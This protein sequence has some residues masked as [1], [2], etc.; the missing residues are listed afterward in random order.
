MS[1]PEDDGKVVPIAGRTKSRKPQ[2]RD[3][4]DPRPV[5]TIK[6]GAI[7][8]AVDA[9]EKALMERGGLYQ[10]ANQIVFLGDAP[11]I[12]HDNR[13]VTA[14][15]IFE[16]G[17]NALAEDIGEAACLMKWD[18]RAQVDVVVDTPTRLVKT[19]QDR[20]GR[21]RFP[22]LTAVVNAP[23]LRAD[24]SLLSAPGYDTATGLFFDPRGVTFP[25]IPA[26]PTR[27]DAER[28]LD[29]LHDLIAGF[30][31]EGEADRAV[32]LS[33]ILTACAR[34]GLRT[35]PMHAFSAPVAGSGKSKLVDI[36]SAIATGREA[37]VVAQTAD[38]AE[39]E[40]RLGALY[41]QGAGIV[42]IDNCVAPVNGAFLCVAL[43]QETVTIRPLGTSTQVEVPTTTFLT[44]T[45]NNLVIA[46]DMTRRAVLAR[47]DPRMERPELREF[48]F[49]PVETAKVHRVRYVTAALTVMLA[50]KAAG[51]PYQTT[52]L[53]SFD[54]WSRRV[55]D[56]LV[57]L[58]C[59]DPVT[60]M[61]Q[62]RE[63][64]PE[65]ASLSEVL[66]QWKL[67]F[68]TDKV[69]VRKVIEKAN[70]Q[71]PRGYDGRSEFDYPDL[72]EALFAVGGQAGAINGRRLG[73]WLGAHA[74]RIVGGHW[75]ETDGVYEG[76]AM[77]CLREQKRDRGLGGYQ[78]DR[79][80]V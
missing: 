52:P 71:S 56:A 14:S 74:K 40:K 30:P 61:E 33:A 4:N 79:L 44:A 51:A 31:F 28:A 6:P 66:T 29:D 76:A 75:I 24:G 70:R 36:A 77:W 38:D 49:E 37:G 55:R 13:E 23:T 11:V 3:E 35:A 34:Q 17:E 32:A 10:R 12:T 68:G 57:W 16:R 27:R 46:G 22:V 47:L 65:L 20:V 62:A 58:G 18:A 48:E 39:M 45:G 42:A 50:Y 5:I 72:R 43:T 41:L 9:V 25:V 80:L 8:A 69:T 1:G 2:H 67:A 26:M 19:L 63:L 59:A 21:F 7:K 78:G 53:G 73:K 54:G 64:D 60:T 15:R